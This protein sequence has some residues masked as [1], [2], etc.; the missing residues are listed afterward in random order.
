MPAITVASVTIPNWQ[1]NSSNVALHVYSIADFTAQDGTL[2]PKSIRAHVSN[3][4]GTFLVS[5]ACSVSGGAL[6]IPSL[7]LESTTDSGDNPAAMYCAELWDN[8]SNQAIQAFGTVTRFPITPTP[9]STT[10]AQI[11]ASAVI[12]Q[13]LTAGTITTIPPT[14]ISIS[15]GISSGNLGTNVVPF[16][17]LAVRSGTVSKCTVS[18]RSSDSVIGLTFRIKRNGVDIF[19]TDPHFAAG[20]A[21]GITTFSTLSPSP[22]TVAANDVFTMDITSGSGA[23]AFTAI[24]ES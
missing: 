20:A 23:W 10:W 6:T 19:S 14:P 18:I 16:D 4:L 22:L 12:S 1:G 2:V 17:I 9:S 15:F 7:T 3:G 21:V 24:L 8:A 5:V 11:F 13:G